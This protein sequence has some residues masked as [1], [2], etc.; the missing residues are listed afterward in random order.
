MVTAKVRFL[1][2]SLVA[3][4]TCK[5]EELKNALEEIGILTPLSVIRLDNSRTLQIHFTPSDEVGELVCGIINPR[6]DTLGNVQR[7]CRHI[8]CFNEQNRATFI[9]K[10]ES[11]EI[12]TV[13]KGIKYAEK[14]RTEK[15]ISR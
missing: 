5:S 1:T 13:S 6:S 8:H 3:E 14:L 2:N 15:G 9:S 10:L 7:L 4:L 12:N 11:G